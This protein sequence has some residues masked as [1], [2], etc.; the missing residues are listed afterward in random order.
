VRNWADATAF[1]LDRR[2]DGRRV[3]YFFAGLL[4]VRGSLD[5][6]EPLIAIYA[7]ILLWNK[8]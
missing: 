6:I 2:S 3:L 7:S 4:A 1:H 8:L 5:V